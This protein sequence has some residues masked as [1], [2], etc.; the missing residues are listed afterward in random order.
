MGRP[1][2]QS[3][4]RSVAAT[5]TRARESRSTMVV[6]FGPHARPAFDVPS[7]Q[8]NRGAAPRERVRRMGHRLLD[9]Q[10]DLRYTP[11]RPGL[12]PGH[13]GNVRSE[14][15]LIYPTPTKGTTDHEDDGDRGGDGRSGGN[16]A[17]RCEREGGGGRQVAG[18]QSR[19]SEQPGERSE[20]H[21]SEL[22]SLA[23][24]VCRLL[25]EKKKDEA[26]T[27]LVQAA[28]EARRV[29]QR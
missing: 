1:P 28:A 15:S 20:E 13:L 23:Y 11:M 4:A 2:S 19:Q 21:T 17:A 25:L 29:W 24:V 16:S 5:P 8:K 9:D 22:Q 26:K 10:P 18:L 7:R 3:P 14:P 6:S 27:L 12:Q